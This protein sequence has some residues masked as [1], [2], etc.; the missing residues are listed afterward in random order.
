AAR[1][2][3]LLVGGTGMYI[4]S[5]TE[6]IPQIPD[7]DESIRANTRS[8]LQEIGADAM[9]TILAKE[10]LGMAERLEKNDSQRISRAYE[11]LKQTGRSL[12]YW[13]EQPARLLY[14][15]E[16]FI[17]FF[18]SPPRQQVYDNCNGRFLK[19]IEAGV[20][21]EIMALGD[22]NLNPELP[23]MKAHGVP[24]LLA[25]L[26]GNMTLE[27]AIDQAQK[28]TRHYIKRQF[29]WFR[30]QMKDTVV[31]EGEGAE[32][33]VVEFVGRHNG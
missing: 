25:Y 21:Q 1:K 20:L 15:K 23:A 33:V 26:N 31:L 14:P 11:V 2:T 4:K 24:E 29:T 6:G 12:A 32:K 28:N 10:D 7:I 30:H 9:H 8:L 5:L 16:D 22:L 18:L 17:K 13:Q 27:A 3:P 19:M